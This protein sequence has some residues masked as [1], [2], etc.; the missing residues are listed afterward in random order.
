MRG[1][2]PMRSNSF[3][4][5]STSL[6]DAAG[7]PAGAAAGAVAGAAV[8]LVAL[9]SAEFGGWVGELV[10]EAAGAGV[11]GA[12]GSASASGTAPKPIQTNIVTICRKPLPRFHM[13]TMPAPH[14]QTMVFRREPS[15]NVSTGTK[16]DC[17]PQRRREITDQRRGLVCLRIKREMTGVKRNANSFIQRSRP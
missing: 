4:R 16:G 13:L 17:S 10:L 9:V 7:C 14:L 3:S 8:E 6:G 12:G 15:G 2:K 1:L 11:F 5:G